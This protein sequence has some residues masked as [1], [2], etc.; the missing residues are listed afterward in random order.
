MYAA[1]LNRIALARLLR[2]YGANCSAMNPGKKTAF[3][4]AIDKGNR[5]L[6]DIIKP[7]LL[8]SIK[9]LF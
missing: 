3:D 5:E 4:I 8:S 2:D 1:K 7:S 9:K 6:A